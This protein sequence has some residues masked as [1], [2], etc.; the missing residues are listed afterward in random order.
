MATKIN[1]YNNNEILE[2]SWASDNEM[3]E[4][5]HWTSCYL[6]DG[7]LIDSGPPGGVKDFRE[8]ITSLEPETVII[9]VLTHSH[10][11]HVGGAHILQEEF[12][13]PIYAS[14]EAIPIIK[15]GYTYPEY[16]Q[17][18][19]GTDLN[20]VDVEL[21]PNPIYSKNRKYCFDLLPIPGHAPDQIAL[22]EKEQ[23][24][25]FVADG[26]IPKYKRIF[27]TTSNIKEDISQIYQSMQNLY[28]FTDKMDDLQIFLSGRGVVFG[29]EYLLN[30][31]QEIMNL[32]ERAHELRELG[33]T[34]EEITR[35]IFPGEDFFSIITNGELSYQNLV[36]SL[37]EWKI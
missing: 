12:K 4:H 11:D 22:I 33:K 6:I 24:W 21:A 15:V 13:I 1:W 27:G 3:I 28:E 34:I 10:E 8:F 31:M 25:T 37:L 30:R 26:V 36:E 2:W 19:W 32:R 18:T 16:R 35:N 14:K 23:Q 7:V 17:I 20:P 5:P 9:C 29:R